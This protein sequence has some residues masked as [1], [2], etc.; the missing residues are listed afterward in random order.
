MFYRTLLVYCFFP[1]LDEDVNHGPQ[2]I[3]YFQHKLQKAGDIVFLLEVECRVLLNLVRF[4]FNSLFLSFFFTSFFS[5]LNVSTAVRERSIRFA[6]E[7]SRGGE[8]N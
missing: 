1:F 7:S 3:L 8:T 5:F 2:T 6:T 4:R